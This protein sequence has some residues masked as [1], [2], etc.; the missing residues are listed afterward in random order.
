MHKLKDGNEYVSM[1]NPAGG[2]EERMAVDSD[3]SHMADTSCVVFK[4]D[5]NV[6]GLVLGNQ[7]SPR[8]GRVALWLTERDPLG[9]CLMFHA[10]PLRLRPL[11]RKLTEGH[12]ARW[13]DITIPVA[14]L[15][16]TGISISADVDDL[17]TELPDAMVTIKES[18]GTEDP[19]MPKALDCSASRR[20]VAGVV[21]GADRAKVGVYQE[22]PSKG[23]EDGAPGSAGCCLAELPSLADVCGG[24]CGSAGAGRAV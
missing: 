17:A 7:S 12:G 13:L 19:G 15:S 14:E 24:K 18:Y 11:T 21:T 23:M 22:V 16:E 6:F 1:M 10:V 2:F 20:P 9:S 8:A 5:T 3:G 4:E